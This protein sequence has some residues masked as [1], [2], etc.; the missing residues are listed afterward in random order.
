MKTLCVLLL[1]ACC[2]CAFFA[3]S[4]PNSNRKNMTRLGLGMTKAQVEAIMGQPDSVQADQDATYWLYVTGVAAGNS[5]MTPVAFGRD[6]KV[7]G[8]GRTKA[9]TPNVNVPQK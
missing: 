7:L 6:G 9:E 1:C 8:L 5:T 3:Y 2:G 4:R